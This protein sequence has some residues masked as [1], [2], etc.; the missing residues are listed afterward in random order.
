MHSDSVNTG[1][2]SVPT[3]QLYI[4]KIKQICRKRSVML[5][6]FMPVLTFNALT[7]H[8]PSTPTPSGV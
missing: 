8:D 2:P 6:H 5:V 1:M 3:A 7:P 4:V